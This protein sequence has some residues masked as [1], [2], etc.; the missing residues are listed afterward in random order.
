[1]EKGIS[2]LAFSLLLHVFMYFLFTKK[3][4]KRREEIKKNKRGVRTQL[5]DLSFLGT[6]LLICNGY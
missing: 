6:V 4:K 3:K 1:M 5:C 2:L